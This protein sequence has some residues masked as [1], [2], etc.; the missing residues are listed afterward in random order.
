MSGY[1]TTAAGTSR[2]TLIIL[3]I[4]GVPAAHGGFETFAE[5]LA[6]WMR[7]KGWDVLVYC[8]GS[9]SGQCEED[10]WQGIRRIHV[11]V[12]G[13]GAWATV[14]FDIASTRD[15]LKVPGVILTLGYNTGFLSGLLR[16]FGR[17]NLINMDGLEWQR[18]K[19]SWAERAY[20]WV[21][22]RIAA[23]S[24]TCLIADHPVIADHLATRTA[25][26]RIATIPYG[27][28]AV[29]AADRTTL[30]A[31]GLDDQR[32]FTIIARPEP[33]NTILE[34]VA[35]FSARPRGARLVVLG[36]YR[37]THAF[38]RAVLDAAG[39]EVIF[40]GAIYDKAIVSA[41]RYHSVAYLH[42]HRVGGTNP[43]LVEALGAGSAVIAHDNPFNRWVAGETAL[44]FDDETGFSAA[45]DRMLADER[46]QQA[47]KRE[48]QRRWAEAFDWPLILS[49]YERLIADHAAAMAGKVR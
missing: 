12:K 44:Y 24:G 34:M 29:H 47:M 2:P 41:L 35:A 27:A 38:E 36:N 13:D 8:Q 20:L 9:A 15:A 21:N 23:W 16:L 14:A 45:V 10:E 18:D 28:D 19:Y 43:S 26:R 6:L 3:G 37:R 32:F 39:E 7:D 40:P 5:R 22:E 42:G 33:E 46:E 1:G 49:D 48:A 31:L 11:P 25:R 4:R 30:S 17:T